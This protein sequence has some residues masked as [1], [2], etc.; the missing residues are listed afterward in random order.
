MSSHSP[1]SPSSTEQ[2]V[3]S[4]LG[5]VFIHAAKGLRPEQPAPPLAWVKV[6]QKLEQE[7]V[8]PSPSVSRGAGLSQ[9]NKELDLLCASL[10]WVFS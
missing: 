9:Q 4:Q 5:R 10:R 6:T 3:N 2:K 8:K 7:K 1:I